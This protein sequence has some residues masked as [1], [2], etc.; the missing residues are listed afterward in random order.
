MAQKSSD[1][2]VG[3]STASYS[4]PGT[5]MAKNAVCVHHF[6]KIPPTETEISYDMGGYMIPTAKGAV[7]PS[8]PP[9]WC[10]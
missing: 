3:A 6:A 1:R 9:P 5:E 2:G 10:P 4:L 8:S 7:V